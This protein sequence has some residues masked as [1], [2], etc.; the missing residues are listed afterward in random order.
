MNCRTFDNLGTNQCRS[1]SYGVNQ[2]RKE[3]L[4]A[5]VNTLRPACI[6][7]LLFLNRDASTLQ[8]FNMY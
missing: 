1:E 3:S 2:D 4:M 7:V 6:F 5:V 8:R